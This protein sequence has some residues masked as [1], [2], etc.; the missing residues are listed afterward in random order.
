MSD[1]GASS[2]LKPF[3]SLFEAVN[4][5]RSARW[6]LATEHFQHIKLPQLVGFFPS[7]MFS[8]HCWF[9]VQTI[10]TETFDPRIGVCVP[11]CVCA[12][13]C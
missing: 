11:E 12:P 6:T 9:P 5:S 8:I 10:L 13:A 7:A 1:G 2:G 3:V 4:D